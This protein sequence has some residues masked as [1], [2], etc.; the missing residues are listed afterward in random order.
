MIILEH[1]HEKC[2]QLK[3]NSISKAEKI[4]SKISFTKKSA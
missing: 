2:K 3:K 1:T 4:I